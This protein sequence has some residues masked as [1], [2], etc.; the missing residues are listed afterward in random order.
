MKAFHKY[1]KAAKSGN[2]EAQ[3]RIAQAYGYKPTVLDNPRL[4]ALLKRADIHIHHP[5]YADQ[6]TLTL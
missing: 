5:L 4:I 3:R 1:N 2:R 6:E